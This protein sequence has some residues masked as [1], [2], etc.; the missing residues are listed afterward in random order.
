MVFAYR[1]VVVVVVVLAVVW[2]RSILS[3][4]ICLKKG[5]NREKRNKKLTT[6][7]KSFF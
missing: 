6:A 3:I 2:V 1:F 7:L 4:S 5:V